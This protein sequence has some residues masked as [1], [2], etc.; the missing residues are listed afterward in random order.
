VLGG[1]GGGAKVIFLQNKISF[2]IPE[3]AMLMD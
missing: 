2:L 3:N 1:G